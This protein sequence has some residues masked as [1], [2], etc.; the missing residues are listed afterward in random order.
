V[1]FP[2]EA[3]PWPQP[4]L[5]IASV[6]SFGFGGS[7]AH[8]IVSD[9]YSYL[10]TR[11]MSGLYRTTVETPSMSEIRRF[12]SD[13]SIEKIH[14]TNING[15]ESHIAAPEPQGPAIIF[16]FSAFDKG[17]IQ[18]LSE[19]YVQNLKSQKIGS[20]SLL[21]QENFL[22]DLAYTPACRRSLFSWRATCRASSVADLVEKIQHL[23]PVLSCASPTAAAFVFTG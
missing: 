22:H 3:M 14:S 6:N 4:G 18:R 10:S 19:S 13:G 12:S 21:S 11:Q 7:N 20:S 17:G 9:A 5:R 16:G 2:L 1:A 23:E 15:T 8:V